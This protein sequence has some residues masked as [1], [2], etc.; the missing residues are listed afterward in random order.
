MSFELDLSRFTKATTLKTETIVR[1]I[2]LD[3]LNRVVKRTPVDT[4]RARANWQ[5][6]VGQ[7]AT[8][9]VDRSDPA[10]TATVTQGIS[11]VNGWDINSSA[12]FLT[13]NVPY[14]GVLERG[15]SE[16]SPSGM[17]AV[18]LAEYPGIVE[19]AAE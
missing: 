19:G 7:P 18:T 17:V 2:S 16:Q 12:L 4:G 11:T 15:S 1:K 9:E 14:I 3:V 13:N 5:T 6:T 10:G 8:S